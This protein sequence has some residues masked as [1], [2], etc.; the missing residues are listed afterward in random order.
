MTETVSATPHTIPGEAGQRLARH[1]DRVVLCDVYDEVGAHIYDDLCRGDTSE[2]AEL[3]T[4]LRRTPGPVLE[5]A[6]GSGRL[7]MPLL[8][9]GREVTALEVSAPMLE[10]LSARLATAPARFR[11]RCAPVRADMSDFSLDRS[12]DAVVLGTTSVS[13]LDERGR[14]GLYRVVREH[15][16][17]NGVFLLSNVDMASSG[18]DTPAEIRTDFVGASGRAY[19]LHEFWAPE[20]NT[21]TITIH[22]ADLDE[23]PV[24]VGTS[25]VAVLSEERL[26]DELVAAGFRTRGRHMLSTTSGRHRHIL[27]EA[28]VAR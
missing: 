27:F 8:A 7:T 6:A 15:L 12:F 19:Q 5:L 17:P 25:T 9:A 11:Q 4:L 28:E 23:W 3:T 13:L 10:L 22:S 2:V 21:R 14:A 26:T 16:T 24:Y 1:D 20:T 18:D